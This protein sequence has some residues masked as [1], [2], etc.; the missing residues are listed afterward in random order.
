[1]SLITYPSTSPYYKTPQSSWA[2]GIYV[3]RPIPADA[4]DERVMLDAKYDMKPDRFSNDVYGTPAYY[5]VFMQRNINLIRDPI[6][7]FRSG[8]IIYVPT[9]DRINSI[10]V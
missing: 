2:I 10:L 5:W 9:L 8:M 7:D 1:M 6:F 4:S 3:D